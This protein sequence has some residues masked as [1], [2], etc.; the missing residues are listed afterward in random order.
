MT[1]VERA[2]EF[3]PDGAR[4]GLGSGRPPLCPA[5]RE[6]IRG[7]NVTGAVTT[8]PQTSLEKPL[9]LSPQRRPTG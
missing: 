9:G 3:V 4:V 8:G 7:P 2:L 1:I 5:F 6:I